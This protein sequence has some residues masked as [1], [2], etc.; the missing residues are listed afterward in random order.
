MHGAEKARDTTLDDKK[1]NVRN[2]RERHIDRTCVAVTAL[3]NQP[4]AFASD[5]GEQLE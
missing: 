1:Y 2:I 4:E 3:S 5:L